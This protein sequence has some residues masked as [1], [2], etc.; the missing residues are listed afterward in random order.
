[1]PYKVF[2]TEEVLAS[3]DVNSYLMRQSVITCTSGTHPASPS[4][5]MTI[6]ETD[7]DRYLGFDGSTWR[8]F[9][10]LNPPACNVARSTDQTISSAVQ[11][12]VTFDTEKYDL[13]NMWN[14]GSPTRLTVPSGAGGIYVIGGVIEYTANAVGARQ[15][16][17]M[18]NGAIVGR[19][20]SD[21]PGSGPAGRVS[22]VRDIALAASDYVE[23]AGYQNSGTTLS[24]VATQRQPELWARRV[25]PSS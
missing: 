16:I 5:G 7:T 21:N 11:T 22:F 20:F 4:E 8:E 17:L 14:S 25:G 12:T 2:T 6:Y 19:T 13:R 18:V 9:A 15:C 23:M 1:V 10:M 3:A 24:M